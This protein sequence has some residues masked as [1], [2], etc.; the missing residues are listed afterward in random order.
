[1]TTFKSAPTTRS[2]G[3][4]DDKLNLAEIV[5]IVTGGEMPMRFTAYDGSATGPEDSPFGLDLVT[6]PRGATYI[7]TAPP[8]I[9]EWPAPTSPATSNPRACI[10]VTPTIY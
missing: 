8:A 7:A 5:E 9:S 10:P 1:M 3:G 6:P 2:A 4:H